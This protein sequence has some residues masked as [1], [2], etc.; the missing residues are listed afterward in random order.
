MRFYN[1]SCCK[2]VIR[3]TLCVVLVQRFV[4]SPNALLSCKIWM[5]LIVLLLVTDSFPPPRNSFMGH[6]TNLMKVSLDVV[7]F[8][9]C[10]LKSKYFRKLGG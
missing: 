10:G 1:Q 3:L 5:W 9:E 7:V 4:Y 2:E 8:I 6:F